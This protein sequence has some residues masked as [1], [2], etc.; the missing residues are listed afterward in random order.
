VASYFNHIAGYPGTSLIQK[1]NALMKFSLTDLK[2]GH[3]I[4]HMFHV[5]HFEKSVPVHLTLFA[6]ASY[7]PSDLIERRQVNFTAKLDKLPNS[8]HR[9]C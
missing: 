9:L 5:A 8:I 6:L 4:I 3:C 2:I 1:P 7:K